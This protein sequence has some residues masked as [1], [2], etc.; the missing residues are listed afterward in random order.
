M[1]ALAIGR[2]DVLLSSVAVGFRVRGEFDLIS[3][4]CFGIGGRRQTAE[5]FGFFYPYPVVNLTAQKRQ[6]SLP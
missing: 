5:S 4:W 6:Q 3:G 2:C 1:N